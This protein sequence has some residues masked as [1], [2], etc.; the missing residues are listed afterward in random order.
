MGEVCDKTTEML[1]L[2]QDL[3]TVKQQL[4]STQDQLQEHKL[5]ID[6]LQQA[7]TITKV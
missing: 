4:A 3:D 6:E 1:I 5:N 7:A 2:E